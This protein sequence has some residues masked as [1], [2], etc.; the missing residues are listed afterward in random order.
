[1]TK[2]FNAALIRMKE[3][4][5]YQKIVDKRVPELSDRTVKQTD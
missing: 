5:V 4:E 3:Q 2:K 1:L